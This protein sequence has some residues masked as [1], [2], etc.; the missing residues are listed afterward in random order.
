M[1]RLQVYDA[2]KYPNG[3]LTTEMNLPGLKMFDKQ[4]GQ[5]TSPQMAL[6]MPLPC[7]LME[8][9]PFTW[10]RVGKQEKRGTGAIR[11]Y[12]YYEN[13]ADAFTGSVNQ[14]LAL[15]FFMF[16]EQVNM[17]LEG[18]CFRGMEELTL[19]GDNEDTAED[20]IITSTV[21]YGTILTDVSAREERGFT[22]IDP[23]VVIEMVKQTTRPARPEFRDGFIIP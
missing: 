7:I 21:D 9:Q 4:M 11:F 22:L 10:I 17:L 3:K 2:V 8:Y 23:T 16:T 1:E 18:Y 20:M 14:T 12:I 13:Y 15:Q 19:T 6:A 5:F